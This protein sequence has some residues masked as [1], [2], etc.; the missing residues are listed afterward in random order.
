[1]IFCSFVCISDF[2]YFYSFF[3][4]PQINRL[5]RSTNLK[6]KMHCLFRQCILNVATDCHF[7][8]PI[9]LRLSLSTDLPMNLFFVY[10]VYFSLRLSIINIS[11]LLARECS[12]LQALQ[13]D[14]SFQQKELFVYLLQRHWQSSQ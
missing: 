4:S 6:K 13:H 10:I 5:L 11:S 2:F 12:Y 14:H 7:T 8:D 1:M 3:F 9:A